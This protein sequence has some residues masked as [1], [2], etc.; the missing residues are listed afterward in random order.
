MALRSGIDT[1]FDNANVPTPEEMQALAEQGGVPSM[2]PADAEDILQVTE[3]DP[4]EFGSFGEGLDD[5]ADTGHEPMS[6]ED[7]E[8]A[9][10]KGIEAA[11]NYIDMELSPDREQAARYY[12]GEL[13]GDEEEGRSAVVM[14]EVRDTVLAIMPALLRI[15]CGTKN[16][17]EFLNNPGTPI[18]QA[19]QQTAYINQIIHRDNQGFEIFYAAFKDALVRRTGIFTWWHEEIETVE[20]ED[21]SGLTEEAYALL[22]LEAKESSSEDENIRY[23]VIVHDKKSDTTAPDATTFDELNPQGAQPPQNFVYSGVIKRVYIKKRHR[24]AAVPPEEFIITPVVTSNVDEFPLVGRRWMKTIG[25]LVAMGHDEDAI[26]EAVGGKGAHTAVSL[27][28][29]AEAIDRNPAANMERLFD[30]GF[31]EVDPA[32]EYVKYCEIYILID[33]D[34]DGIPERRKVCTVGDNKIIYDRVW[35]GMVPFALICPDPE[36]HSPFGYGVADQTMDMQEVKSEVVRGVLD[37][38]AESIIP[39]MGIVEGGVNID[40]ALSNRR[41]Q[42]VRMKAQGNLQPLNQPFVGMNAMPV[43]QYMDDVKARRTGITISPAGL[44][45]QTLQSTDSTAAQATVDASQER[46]EMIARIFAETGITRLFRGLLQQVVRHQDRK[47]VLRIQGQGVTVDPRSFNADLDLHVNVG[48]GRGT[49]AK[50][51]AGLQFILGM[52][53]DLLQTWGFANP[54]VNLHHVSNAAEDLI[55]EQDFADVSRY[56]HVMSADEA[57]KFRQ[58]QAAQPPK[59]TPEELLYKANQ[60]KVMADQNK[61]HEAE[62]TKRLKLHSDDEFRHQKLHS[63]FYTKAADILGKYGIQITEQQLREQEAEEQASDKMADDAMNGGQQHVAGL[64]PSP[65]N[66]GPTQ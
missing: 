41:G 30:T 51:I 49:S 16:A 38:L 5:A 14:T 31:S 34:G 26:R 58:Q 50:R 29:N 13:F 60:E 19:T 20:E 40:D 12:R 63:D 56:M 54:L 47:R 33:K 45:P 62:Q 61:A 17:V 8:N 66:Q 52:Q 2:H 9:V 36:P 15:F 22:Q 32:S 18:A 3:G 11:E 37:S 64:L 28:T 21:F 44:D 35:G 24:V 39:R 59:P 6:D 1:L 27:N 7:Y 46:P 57:E 65:Q 42:L 53:K 48:L 10:N 43:L 23:Q 55:R 25:E 4:G